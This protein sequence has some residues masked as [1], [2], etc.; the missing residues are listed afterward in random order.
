MTRRRIKKSKIRKIKRIGIKTRRRRKQRQYG[1]ALPEDIKKKL[2]DANIIKEGDDP[3]NEFVKTIIETKHFLK[4]PF[5]SKEQMEKEEKEREE[6][7]EK[8]K[9]EKEKA[10]AKKHGFLGKLKSFFTRK[11]PG[12]DDKEDDEEEEEEEIEDFD[13]K[14]ETEYENNDEEVFYSS[15][16]N[17][18]IQLV[19]IE[20]DTY[21]IFAGFFYI[22]TLPQKK[23]RFSL[24]YTTMELT[25]TIGSDSEVFK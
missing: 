21:D 13:L 19:T 25:I 20:T 10:K 8:K 11:K 1:G 22:K 7:R 15:R 14:K 17:N 18:E 16:V 4:I 6:R 3:V 9:Q 2:V 24:D 23:I 5:K 12:Q